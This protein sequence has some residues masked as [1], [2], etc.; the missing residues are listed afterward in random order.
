LV[1]GQKS[2]VGKVC[3]STTGA[4]GEPASKLKVCYTTTNNWYIS[5]VQAWSN[6]TLAYPKTGKEPNTNVAIGKFPAKALNL[7]SLMYN[8]VCVELSL[9]R[10]GGMN[11]QCNLAQKYND[12]MFYLLS[13]ATVFQYNWTSQ[14][15]VQSQTAWGQ[16]TSI[17]NAG[18]WA[19]YTNYTMSCN[20]ASRQ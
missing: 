15:V 13:H 9:C 1:A 4:T 20:C 18:S 16:G 11:A 10:D 19:M 7:T 5:E 2:I 8:N 3:V 14:A 6:K 12:T 17:S